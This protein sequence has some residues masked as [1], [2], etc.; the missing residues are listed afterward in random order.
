MDYNILLAEISLL[1]VNNSYNFNN[2][3]GTSNVTNF[4]FLVGL[5]LIGL[6]VDGCLLSTLIYDSNLLK[7]QFNWL[8]FHQSICDFLSLIMLLIVFIQERNV[9]L[10]DTALYIFNFIVY[11]LISASMWM[12]A[13]KSFF[14]QRSLHNLKLCSVN[15]CP[16]TK[17]AALTKSLKFIMPVW[18]A[19]LC[20]NFLLPVTVFNC[21]YQKKYIR[22]P[23]EEVNCKY[24]FILSQIYILLPSV[25]SMI[26]SG[27]T[28]K[29]LMDYKKEWNLLGEKNHNLKNMLRKR[30]QSTIVICIFM[31]LF[32][33]CLA[34]SYIMIV[35]INATESPNNL[36]S[37]W[38]MICIDV[39]YLFFI[40]NPFVFFLVC[41][42]V[43]Q[44][45]MNMIIQIV[46]HLVCMKY[47]K[48]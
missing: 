26:F 27:I 10:S 13:L 17:I 43:Q 9:Q 15:A 29:K 19:T 24:Y 31:L 12:I 22:Y 42:D 18:I 4:Y 39:N 25:L 37:T 40:F 28:V 35:Y 5:I 7:K 21:L 45:F 8:V 46:S 36:N 34:P 2:Y 11:A 16:T 48:K 1:Q 41:K 20:L 6:L 47:M 33:I 14:Q 30:Q 23:P 44:A 32:I 3:N 38:L